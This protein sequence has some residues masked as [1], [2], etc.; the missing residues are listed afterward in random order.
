VAAA[1]LRFAVVA[2]SVI[3]VLTTGCAHTFDA[4][5]VGVEATMA[6]PASAPAQGEA[7]EINR[8]AVFF[9]WGMV[10]GSQPSLTDVLNAQ[11]TSTDQVADLR[12]RVRSRFSD[13]L[14]TILTAGLIVPRSVT[15]EGVVV[16]P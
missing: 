15:Y 13:V 4:S 8:K 14:I 3:A 9:F 12:V 6:S 16:T 1:S 11:V 10:P 2:A 7:F 5:T